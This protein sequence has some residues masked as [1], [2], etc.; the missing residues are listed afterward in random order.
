MKHISLL[1]IGT[2]ALALFLNCNPTSS[3]NNS[4]PSVPDSPELS[5]PTNGA[6]NISITPSLTWGTVNGTTSYRVQVSTTSTFTTMAIDDSLLSVNSKTINSSLN[7]NTTYYWRVNAK[8]TSGT[9]SWSSAWSFST[10]ALTVTDVEG[11]IYH[12]ITIG[13]QIW[14]VENLKTTK[15]NDGTAIPNVTDSATWTNLTTPGYCWY[16][17]DAATYKNKYGALY[18]WYVINTG[19]LAPTGWHVPSIAEWD[20]L[21]NYLIA[22]GFNY[23]GTTTGNKIAKSMAA[24]TDWNIDTSIGS[25]GNDLNNNNKSGF[26]ALPG[27][28]RHSQSVFYGIGGLCQFS[29]ATENGID[30]AYSCFLIKFFNNVTNATLFNSKKCGYSV[31]LVK[32]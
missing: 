29:S 21:Q 24:K 31:R 5:S 1:S 12:T 8:N 6:T 18:N 25:I 14:T 19:L 28:Y 13:N 11:N 30:C 17:N 2:M 20:T 16:N 3:D 23:D 15:Y 4:L 10:A 9:G 22:N 32:D 27:G 26:S 7:N